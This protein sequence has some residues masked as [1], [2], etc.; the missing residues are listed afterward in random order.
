MSI[1]LSKALGLIIQQKKNLRFFARIDE[2]FRFAKVDEHTNAQS[3]I[4]L[5][6][7]N[8][9]SYEVGGDF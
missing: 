5:K 4:G 1:F 7:Q 2:N 8:G 3:C 6:D 9:I